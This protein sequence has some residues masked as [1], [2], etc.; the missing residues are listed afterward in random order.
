MHKH[1]GVPT[2][3]WD[4]HTHM[5]THIHTNMHIYTHIT[6][7]SLANMKHSSPQ[8]IKVITGDRHGSMCLYFIVLLAYI[9]NV[10]PIPGPPSKSSSPH[11]SSPLPLRGCSPRPLPITATLEGGAEQ[12]LESSLDTIQELIS[13]IK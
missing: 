9:S 10:A 12:S 5:C 7:T 11:P 8:S 6:H 13:N 4:T 3:T 2:C 1:A